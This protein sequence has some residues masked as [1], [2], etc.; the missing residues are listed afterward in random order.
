MQTPIVERLGR[1]DR[2]RAAVDREHPPAGAAA[3]PRRNP[4]GGRGADVPRVRRFDLRR[5]RRP[6]G[7][8]RTHDVVHVLATNAAHSIVGH[9]ISKSGARI[10]REK[11]AV[12]DEAAAGHERRIVAGQ[13]E[14]RARDLDRL[15]EAAE[16]MRRLEDVPAPRSD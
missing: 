15:G 1:A 6:S 5:R 10:I 8:R 13:E 7:R 9:A 2:D 16:R 11:A 12:D 4:R 14:R 3:A